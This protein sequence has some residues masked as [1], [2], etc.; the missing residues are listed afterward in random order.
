MHKVRIVLHGSE[1]NT[2]LEIDLT[3]YDKNR[4]I[5]IAKKLN[6]EARSDFAPTMSVEVQMEI[7]EVTLIWEKVAGD[8]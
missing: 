2:T 7:E 8:E 6:E 4:I 3:T 1:D 5:D